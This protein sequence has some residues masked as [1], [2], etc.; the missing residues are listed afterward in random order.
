MFASRP[1]VALAA[2][3]LT[4]AVTAPAVAAPRTFV[5]STGSDTNN[6]SRATPCRTFGAALTKT[7]PG[8]ELI[9]LDTAGYG[10][11]TI[12]QSV[13]IVASA[14]IYAGIAV[15]GGS[16][17][18]TINGPGIIVGLKGITINGPGVYGIY[19]QDGS[20]RLEDVVISNFGGTGIYMASSGS[21]SVVDTVVRDAAY[22]GMFIAGG[23]GVNLVRV[24]VEDCAT[25]SSTSG[26]WVASG[27]V[28]ISE[29]VISGNVTGGNGAGIYAQ[30]AAAKV[31]LERSVVTRN[32]FY[33]VYVE[34]GANL[35]ATG[36]TVTRN[37]AGVANSLTPGT[38]RLMGDNTV[39]ENG[40]GN[41]LGTITRS[42]RD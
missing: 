12:T 11:V 30:G 41:L 14:G 29:S 17:G 38:V 18:I 40:G 20:A 19:V 33:G 10:T 39:Q 36:N 8:G 6:C 4:A 22:H 27:E 1:L 9:V 32:G 37:S 7:D 2:A 42:A 35:V 26:I 3:M 24:R 5:G 28:L 25:Q 31:T 34:A 16:N 15:P 23:G 21:L 13:S